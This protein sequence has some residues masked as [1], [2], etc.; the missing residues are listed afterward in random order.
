LYCI[1]QEET[2]ENIEVICSK[3]NKIP[4]QKMIIFRMISRNNGKPSTW[5]DKDAMMMM[6]ITRMIIME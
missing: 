3:S 5:K 4:T 6:I 1:V 2:E